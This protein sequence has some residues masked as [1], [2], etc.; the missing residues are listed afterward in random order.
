MGTTLYLKFIK[1]QKYE[2]QNK[3]LKNA[4]QELKIALEHEASFSTMEKG[5]RRDGA[6]KT[7]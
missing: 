3:N 6:P 1:K 2:K 4:S 7:S 5:W